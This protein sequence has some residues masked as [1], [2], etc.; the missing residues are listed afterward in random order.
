MN[1]VYVCKMCGH[2]YDPRKGEPLQNLKPGIEF[3]DLPETWTCPVCGFSK[4]TYIKA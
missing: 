2:R 1:D 4:R 3:S